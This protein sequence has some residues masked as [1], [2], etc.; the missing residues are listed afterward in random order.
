LE[1]DH[2]QA[3]VHGGART[4]CGAKI[5]THR[6]AETPSPSA[7]SDNTGGCHKPQ[8]EESQADAR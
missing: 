2:E 8:C 6:H 7:P 1:H 3:A 5:R 4:P